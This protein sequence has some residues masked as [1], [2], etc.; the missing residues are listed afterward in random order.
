MPKTPRVLNLTRGFHLKRNQAD[1][2]V[3]NCACVW[4][5]F[6]KTVRDCTLAEAIQL[7]N[8]QAKEREPLPM[9]EWPGCIF[10]PPA[11]KES[12]LYAEQDL[13]RQA[14]QFARFVTQ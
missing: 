3:E 9:A 8:Q 11:G 6:G 13:A 14:N 4:V 1:K 5:E 10:R 7:R 2:A 12:S